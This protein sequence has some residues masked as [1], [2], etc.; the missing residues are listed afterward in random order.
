MGKR[1]RPPKG[2]PPK[3]KPEKKQPKPKIERI[4]KSKNN[5]VKLNNNI[6]N[7][8]KERKCRKRGRKTKNNDDNLFTIDEMLGYLKRNYASFNIE[9]NGNKILSGLHNMREF[10]YQQYILDKF[11]YN[12][13]TYYCDDYGSVINTDGIL[14]GIVVRKYNGEKRIIL[15]EN[16]ENENIDDIINSI[17][18]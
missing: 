15:F 17:E 13:T 2:T 11:V 18:K 7:L 14:N 5:F 1:G 6:I 4:T 3:S 10:G 12:N 8:N 16:N 9:I